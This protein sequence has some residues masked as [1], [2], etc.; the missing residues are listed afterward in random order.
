[1]LALTWGQLFTKKR[2]GRGG[3]WSRSLGT[4]QCPRST[5][6]LQKEVCRGLFLRSTGQFTPRVLAYYWVLSLLPTTVWAPAPRSSQSYALPES[7][8]LRGQGLKCQHEL[9]SPVLC[10]GI[11]QRNGSDFQIQTTPNSIR[12]LHLQSDRPFETG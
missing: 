2:E 4:K 9:S 11:L 10:R 7:S 1:M 5:V 12:V 3:G 8:G 6:G